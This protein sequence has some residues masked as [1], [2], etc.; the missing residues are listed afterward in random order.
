MISYSVK[1]WSPATSFT[2]VSSTS[3]EKIT[4]NYVIVGY[5]IKPCKDPLVGSQQIFLIVWLQLCVLISNPFVSEPW[6]KNNFSIDKQA[7]LWYTISLLETLAIQFVSHL[8]DRLFSKVNLRIILAL[9]RYFKGM[10][11][12][13]KIR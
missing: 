9:W 10:K 4:T 7:Q 12:T 1:V 13:S 11:N 3:G 2:I 8:N 6:Y 5:M